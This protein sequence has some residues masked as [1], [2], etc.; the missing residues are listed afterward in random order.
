VLGCGLSDEACGL[1]LWVT[2]SAGEGHGG[3]CT[4]MKEKGSSCENR[5][6]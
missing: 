1:C 4:W 2:L 5:Q 3:V 6:R